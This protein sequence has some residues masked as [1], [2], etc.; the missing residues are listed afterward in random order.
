M[1][2]LVQDGDDSAGESLSELLRVWRRR[3]RLRASG[4]AAVYG[5]TPGLSQ[6][7]VA[8]LSGVSERWYR[9]LE[10]GRPANFSADFLDGLAAALQLSPAER[11]VLYL[12]ATGRPPALPETDAE[13]AMDDLLQHF[14]DSQA[15]NPAYASDV[16]WNIVGT[17][18]PL[19]DWFPWAPH[20]AN[21]MRWAL[22]RPEAR[23]QL[24]N[25]RDDWARP[26]LGQ[27]R[28]ARARHPKHTALRE[29]ERDILAGS[30][31]VRELWALG[32]VH[33]H[34]DG[35]VRRLRLPFHGGTEVS[36]SVVTMVPMRFRA[37]RV[38]VL[39]QAPG[40]PEV[41]SRKQ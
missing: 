28:Y 38:V 13:G 32:E 39:M 8:Q 33:E 24:V 30:R 5:R 26:Y 22:L 20:G 14:L 37:L 3:P 9:S 35:P 41:R 6:Q 4:S 18:D 16:A 36:V 1:D 29:L 12:K 23:Q 34:G 31:E 15:P 7:E 21:L 2:P 10:R 17:N 19:V 27:I 25:W 40:G 11:H